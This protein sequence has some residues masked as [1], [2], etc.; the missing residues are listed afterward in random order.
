MHVGKDRRILCGV[1][2]VT[3]LAG[4]PTFKVVLMSEPV[5]ATVSPAV[6]QLAYYWASIDD[7]T[8]LIFN[9]IYRE[10]PNWCSG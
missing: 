4:V 8:K 10:A 3:R 5:T 6:N 9:Q 1:P 7:A 2:Q